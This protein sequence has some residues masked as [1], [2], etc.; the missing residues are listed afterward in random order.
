MGTQLATAHSRMNSDWSVVLLAT[1]GTR[2]G[3]C[4]DQTFLRIGESVCLR[5][6]CSVMI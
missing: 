5:G 6:C 2:P 1:V 4:N 3:S